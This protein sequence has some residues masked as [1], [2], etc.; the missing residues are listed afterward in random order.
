MRGVVKKLGLKRPLG[1]RNH[2]REDNIKIEI[3]GISYGNV[4]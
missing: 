2:S 4:D 3:K 1:K